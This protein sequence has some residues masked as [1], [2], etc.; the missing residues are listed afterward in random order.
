MSKFLLTKLIRQKVAAEKRTETAKAMYV[1]TE[2]KT[3]T[4]ET[5]TMIA[6]TNEMIANGEAMIAKSKAM[7]AKTRAMPV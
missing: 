5:H 4:D 3:M 7:I 1:E 6:E 2:I